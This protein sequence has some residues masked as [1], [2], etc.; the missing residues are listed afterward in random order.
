MTLHTVQGNGYATGV[1]GDSLGSHRAC[2]PVRKIDS[3]L[4]SEQLQLSHGAQ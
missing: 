4:A 3:N 1:K 2:S